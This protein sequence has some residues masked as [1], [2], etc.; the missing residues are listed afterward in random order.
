MTSK[1]EG[2]KNLEHLWENEKKWTKP[3][4]DAGWTVF[5]SVILER[6]QALG[7][8]AIDVNIL[9]H[10]VRHWWYSENLPHP[11]KETIA[12]CMG[13]SRSTIQKRIARMEKDGLIKRVA[14]YDKGRGGQQTNFYKFEGLI[15]AATPFAKEAIRAKKKQKEETAKRTRRKRPLE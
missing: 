15:E 9:L 7:L 13:V 6:Q 8:D 1:N 11:S 14:R 5:P 12:S 2:T 4:M 10:L 3:L